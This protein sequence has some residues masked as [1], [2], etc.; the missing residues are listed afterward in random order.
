M[1]CAWVSKTNWR[2]QK[3]WG[4]DAWRVSL[5]GELD[6][7]NPMMLHVHA[8]ALS[9]NFRFRRLI[10]SLLLVVS[11]TVTLWN[12]NRPHSASSSSHL[13]PIPIL[14]PPA[15]FLTDLGKNVSA[16][17]PAKSIK[18][19]KP[20]QPDCQ[21]FLTHSQ[22][23][24]THMISVGGLPLKHSPERV[25]SIPNRISFIHFNPHFKNPRY[26]CSIE[27][28]SRQNPN[29]NIT[30]FAR[31]VSDFEKALKSIPI[32]A[33]AAE[34][35]SVLTLDWLDMFLDTPLESWFLNGTHLQSRWVDQNLGNAFRLALLWKLGG[36]YLDLDIISLNP[37]GGLGRT[38][39]KQTGP[40]IVNN[41]FFSLERHDPFEW[42]MM[43]EFVSG[44]NGTVWGRNGPRMVERTY[45]RI[46]KAASKPAECNLDIA[47][48]RVFF[49]FSFGARHKFRHNWRKRCNIMKAI[50]EHS[51]GV[52]WWNKG[53]KG[54]TV[55]TESILEVIM[56][57]H[58]PGVYHAFGAKGLGFFS[59]GD[60]KEGREKEWIGY[61]ETDGF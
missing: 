1:A 46:C 7:T 20:L 31:N 12:M 21:A 25:A 59:S 10:V 11:L 40:S 57:S 56:Q 45:Q 9:R 24:G 53:M 54:Q 36:V 28:A 55:T 51:I 32:S 15:A 18:P 35:I 3:I 61:E 14:E 33:S 60:I 2:V 26:L 6:A 47:L 19:H 37:L 52:H 23:P 34:K 17:D 4:L 48:P 13:K 22:S 8:A 43:K 50:S 41:A 42:E 58:C 49:P 29:H 39:A 27:S 16:S 30:I 44:F 5:G 38:L